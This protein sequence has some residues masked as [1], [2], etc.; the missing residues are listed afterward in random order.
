MIQKLTI[1]LVIAASLMGASAKEERT[2]FDPTVVDDSN[3]EWCYG[4]RTTTVLGSPWQPDVAQFTFDGSIFAK[5]NAELHFFVGAD[6]KPILARQ[7]TW[8]HGWLPII[9]YEWQ[10][11][12]LLYQLEAFGSELE[13]IGPKNVVH[14]ARL[15]VKNTGSSPQKVELGAALRGSGVDYRD[16]SP[17]ALIGAEQK[18][19]I[20]NNIVSVDGVLSAIYQGDNISYESVLDTPYSE[21][22]SGFNAGIRIDTSYAIASR[23]GTLAAGE[24]MEL[25]AVLPRVRTK[26]SAERELILNANYDTERQRVITFWEDF[27]KR[28]TFT[29]PEQRIEDSHRASLVHLALATR[30][31]DGYKGRRQGSGLPYPKLFLNDYIDM[32]MAWM[33]SGHDHMHEYSVE[34]IKGKQVTDTGMFIDVHNRGNEGIVTSHGHAIFSLAYPPVFTNDIEAGKDVFPYVKK[35]IDLLIRDHKSGKYRGLLRPTVPYDAPMVDGLASCHN[36]LGL[37]GLR[38]S[39]RLAR[40]IGE[41][42]LADEWMKIDDSY[43]KAIVDAVTDSFEKEGYVRSHV[44]PDLEITDDFILKDKRHIDAPKRKEFLNQDWENV[45]MGYPS[46]LLATDNPIFLKT[47]DVIRGRK[48]REGVSTYRN[49][50][51]IHQYNTVNMAHQFLVTGQQEK[52]LVDLYHI[53]LHNGPTHEGFENLVDPWTNRTPYAHCPPPHAWAAAKI[54]LFLRNMMVLEYGGRLGI[55]ADERNLH[56]FNLIAPTW[57]VAGEKMT[58]NAIPTEFGDISGEY[59]FV[60]GG[61]EISIDKKFWQQPKNIV[62]R[63]PYFVELTSASS[64]AGEP[65]RIGDELYFKPEVTSVKL[66]WKAKPDAHDG[67]VQKILTRY[68]SEYPEPIPNGMYAS[69]KRP[70]ASLSD[71]EQNWPATPLSFKMVCD[72][73]SHEYGRRY[74]EQAAAGI[75]AVT[76][77]APK[78]QAPLDAGSLVIDAP[79]RT[80]NAPADASCNQLFARY[81]TDGNRSSIDFA[82]DA[83]KSGD[84][85]QVTLPDDTVLTELTIVANS[86]KNR[87][88]AKYV[89][90]YSPE[91]GMWYPLVDCSD[92]ADTNITKGSTHKFDPVTAN[93]LRVRAVLVDKKNP[94][95]LLEVIIP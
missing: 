64:D 34:W 75:K 53:L 71:E 74:Q 83:Q 65:K 88:S 32:M 26:D 7:R 31:D 79:G 89:I 16:G 86:H 19:S 22:F 30:S 72:T 82:W 44:Y 67:T 40:L 21:P 36:M 14:F 69:Y 1:P 56:L 17:T 3:R 93:Y 52:A 6:R 29:V 66:Q 58:I 8:M 27:F 73:F 2:M 13:N 51:H 20:D 80:V 76:V 62:L 84:W 24:S 87:S 48:Y 92:K 90:E 35:G 61:A 85:W 94:F 54:S 50:M 15:T 55:D 49:G 5:Q 41:D 59:R 4:G 77:T 95:K 63:V 78:L 28:G 60:D 57:A 25:S 81:A 12:D 33:R 37:A 91:G 42:Q 11:G 38:A 47:L 10:E 68:R 9:S 39:I 46:E 23:K 18:V 70:V 45:Y 43:T